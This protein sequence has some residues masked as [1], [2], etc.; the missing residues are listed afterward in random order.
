MKIAIVYDMAYPY[1]FGGGEK[2]SWE[3]ARRLAARGH[4]VSLVSIQMWEGES[5]LVREG[6]SCVGVGQWRPGF[7]RKG[8]RSPSEPFY[9][10]YHLF[11]YLRRSEFDIIDCGNF[12]YLPCIAAWMATL[13]K[14]S[15]LVITW[16]E[17]R[18]LRRWIDHKGWLG[19]IAWLLELVTFRLTRANVAISRFT[20]ERASSALRMKDVVVVPCGV[21]CSAGGQAGAAKR[22]QVL[23]VG[24][25]V[26]YKR[27]DMLI[28]AFQSISAEFPNYVLKIVG[29]GPAR[30]DLIA[31]ADRLGIGDRVV[32]ASGVSDEEIL[33]EYARS[34]VFALPSEQEG[35]GIVLVEAMAA[36]TPVVA[37][38][39]PDSAAATLVNDGEDGL[40]VASQ[41]ELA[42]GLRRLLLDDDLRDSM[43]RAAKE[44]AQQYDWDAVVIPML[45]E[46][47]RALIRDKGR[48]GEGSD[49]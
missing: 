29:H 37:L 4:E 40:L 38:K 2:R 36:G 39:A 6:V 7:I 43:G 17:V 33:G 13:F 32:F 9:F 30:D 26:G 3:V 21:E 20:E 12:P 22:D 41:E 15:K 8:K 11:H 1:R 16:Y 31:L 28:E 46:Y 44:T 25:L 18:G 23:S 24:R 47:Y 42:E 49:A 34:K 45:E 27:V 35:F 48:V 19:G 10:A 5:V 14:R